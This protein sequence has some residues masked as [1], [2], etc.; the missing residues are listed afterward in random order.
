MFLPPAKIILLK[1]RTRSE[2][3]SGEQPFYRAVY[4]NVVGLT[5]IGKEVIMHQAVY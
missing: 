5:S 4:K 1:L 2:K 3:F